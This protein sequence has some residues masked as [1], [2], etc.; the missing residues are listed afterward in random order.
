MTAGLRPPETQGG[1]APGTGATGSGNAAPAP[2]RPSEPPFPVARFSQPADIQPPDARPAPPAPPG[3]RP[4]RARLAVRQVRAQAR[5]LAAAVG[6]DPLGRGGRRLHAAALAH[7][8]RLAAAEPA[9]ARRLVRRARRIWRRDRALAATEARLTARLEG[10]E[11]ATPLFLRLADPA[12]G[13]TDAPRAASPLP[14][15]PHRPPPASYCRRAAGPCTCRPS[16]PRRSCSI[17]RP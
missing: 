8:A 15:W 2:L 16:G 11:A 13:L 6:P 7:I 10:W 4:G 14:L 9:R 1:D 3:R 5:A 12:A 17:P